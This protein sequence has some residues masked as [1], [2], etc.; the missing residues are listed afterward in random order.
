MFFRDYWN[1]SSDGYP[2]NKTG[3]PNCPPHYHLFFGLSCYSLQY[4][5]CTTIRGIGQIEIDEIHLGID[6]QGRQYVLLVQAK[7]GGDHLSVVQTD[8]PPRMIR[9]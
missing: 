7:G 5:L 9:G 8:Q 4:Q 6:R 2:R 3:T 1:D